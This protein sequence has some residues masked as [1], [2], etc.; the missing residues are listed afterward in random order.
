MPEAEKIAGGE[1]Y[2][3]ALDQRV[4]VGDRVDVSEGFAAHLREE[5]DD[6][7][8]VDATTPEPTA[9]DGSAESAGDE[10]APDDESESADDGFDADAFVDRTPMEDVVEDIRAGEVDDHLDAV[11]EAADRVGVED[12]VGERRAELEG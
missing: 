8:I 1:V 6:F 5:R 11:A 2:L 4:S 7:R 3:R 12:A 10:G 9:A